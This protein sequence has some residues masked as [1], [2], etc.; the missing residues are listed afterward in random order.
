MGTGAQKVTKPPIQPMK[1]NQIKLIDNLLSGVKCPRCPRI[2]GNKAA[3]LMHIGRTHTRSIIPG[4]RKHGR[5]SREEKLAKR[6][7]YARK[8]REKKGYTPKPNARKSNSAPSQRQPNP[9]RRRFTPIVFPDPTQQQTQATFNFCPNCGEALSQ[10][11]K[12]SQ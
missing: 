3:L 4:V 5:L 12:E 8:W 6:R 1:K 7:D 11:K 9:Y 10:W 2:F